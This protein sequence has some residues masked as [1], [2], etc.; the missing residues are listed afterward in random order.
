MD[1]RKSRG[2]KSQ[3]R[4]EER[5]SEKR[6]SERKEDAGARTGRKVA[7]HCVF[8]TER[9]TDR[10]AGRQTYIHMVHCLEHLSYAHA[11]S[12]FHLGGVFFFN[13]AFLLLIKPGERRLLH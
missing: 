3:R 2:G 7:K 6:K 13:L 9:Q 12:G 5:R 1:R 11:D 8:P 4:E 10:Q